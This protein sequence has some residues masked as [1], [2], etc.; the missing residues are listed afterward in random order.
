MAWKI[1]LRFELMPVE[2]NNKTA[3]NIR[4]VINEG[5]KYEGVSVF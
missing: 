2:R 1:K 3:R 4:N 5:K